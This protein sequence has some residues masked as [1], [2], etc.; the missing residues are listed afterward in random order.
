VSS[1]EVTIRPFTSK[2]AAAFC[3]LNEEWI[4]KYFAVE[5]EDRLVLNDPESHII[6]KGGHIFMAFVD[7]VTAG[8]CALIAMK[9][10]VFELAKMAV[11]VPFQNRG[12]GRKIL[13]YTIN[14]ARLIG[15]NSLFL[16]S[17][18]KLANAIHLYEAH[19]FRRLKADEAPCYPYTRAN[20]FMDLRL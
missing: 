5:E 8:C 2:D 19:G 16:G 13:T 4:T 1:K 9:P 6:R 17:N 20:V 12:I 10:G 11:A 3:R 7:D 18:T 15:A 14:Q